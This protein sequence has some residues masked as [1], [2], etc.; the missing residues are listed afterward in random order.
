MAFNHVF[1]TI[2]NKQ[3]LVG[4]NYLHRNGVIAVIC[5]SPFASQRSRVWLEQEILRAYQRYYKMVRRESMGEFLHKNTTL[6]TIE[7]EG[8]H[9]D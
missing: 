2:R 6:I 4:I 1:E 3:G 5:H 8:L 7:Q 9:Y